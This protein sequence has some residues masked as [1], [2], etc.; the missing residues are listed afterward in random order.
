MILID[1]NQVMISNLMV[2]INNRSE[3]TIE[4]IRHTV[5][6]SL[7]S[8]KRKF[9]KEYGDLVL[10]YDSKRY[11]RRSFFEHY[12][13]N[14]KKD[15]EKSGHDWNSIFDVLNQVR[16]EIKENLPYR[17]VVVE[18]TEAD[19]VIAVLCK[20]QGIIN[21]RLQNNMQPPSKV[22]ILSGD[23]DFIQLQ[24]YSFVKQYNPVQ[25][26]YVDGVDPK[27]YVME[28]VV[29]GDRSDGIPNIFSQDD[30]FAIG[31]RQKPVPRKLLNILVNS[32]LSDHLNEQQMKNWER[33]STLIDL[34]KIPA[35]VA[36]DI[37]NEYYSV[38]P[39]PKSKLYN[40]LVQNGLTKHLETIEEF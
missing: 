33:N 32:N 25:K 21:T 17:V 40:Y 3:L 13:S 8:Y 12:K 31:M 14:R 29:K 23:K 16:Q 34:E 6:N 36:D 20:E 18:G 4:L 30:T 24:K 9:G 37:L 7:K 26:K 2:Q 27:V 15:R 38:S 28:H 19:D 35:N 10:C 5:L 39:A 11:W 22:L 1:M